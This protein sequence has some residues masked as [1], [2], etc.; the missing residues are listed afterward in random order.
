MS[1]ILEALRKSEEDRQQDRVP[2]LGTHSKLI[3]P[4]PKK[5][6]LWPVI[7]LI[8]LLLN[9]AGLFYWLFYRSVE[10]G[11]KT[12]SK[13][14][15]KSRPVIHASRSKREN[16]P[17]VK[18]SVSTAKVHKVP[19][20]DNTP[21][22]ITPKANRVRRKPP[23][24]SKAEESNWV[25]PVEKEKINPYQDI[26]FISELDDSVKRQ[27]PAMTFSSHIYSNEEKNRRVM[28][29]NHYLKEGQ[30]FS[31]M[32]LEAITEDAVVLNFHGIRFR[33]PALK[34]WSYK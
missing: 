2:N 9:A 26:P 1:Y 29:N 21:E 30:H 27:I 15:I 33:L 12:V 4:I 24:I 19:D 8:A 32:I 31:G 10:S 14:F 11:S 17:P 20:I 34:D 13:V 3:R 23:V 28:I 16:L 25:K 18:L 22:L 6:T 7:L 5:T